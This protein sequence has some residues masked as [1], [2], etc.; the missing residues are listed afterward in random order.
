MSTRAEHSVLLDI[1]RSGDRLVAVGERG[2]ILLSD[3]DGAHWR[4]VASPVSVTLTAVQFATPEM[5]WAVGHEG[6]VLHSRD[7]GTTWEKQLDG[8]QAAQLAMAAANAAARDAL[9]DAEQRLKEAERLDADGPDKP[10]LALHFSNARRGIVVG[11]YGLIFTTEDGGATWLPAMHRVDNPRGL[12]LYA[13]QRRGDTTWLTGELG[14]LARADG[15]GTPFVRIETPYA[16]SLFS[17]AF[18]AHDQLWLFG[19][20]GNAWRSTD[21]GTTFQQLA[22]PTPAS[23]IASTLLSDGRV[24]AL[25]QAGQLLIEAGDSLH[26]LSVPPGAPLTSA[27]LASDGRLVAS[28]WSGPRRL[29]ANL[30]GS[31]K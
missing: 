15:D 21:G 22:V 24:V 19:L 11:A 9:P 17:M 6:V 4:Q 28:S 2:R 23:L 26:A 3:D 18:G 27:V 5:G 20:R 29:P 30:L 1:A 7:G 25:N 8:R 13:V 12:H 31:P 14:F 16:G 10:F